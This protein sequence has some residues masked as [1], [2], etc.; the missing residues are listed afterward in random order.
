MSDDWT[1][2]DE[3]WQ[4]YL[5]VDEIDETLIIIALDNDNW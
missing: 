5:I 2:N 1:D 4:D 3:S